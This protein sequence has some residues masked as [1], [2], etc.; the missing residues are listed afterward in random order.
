M[1]WQTRRAK[2]SGEKRVL[3]HMAFRRCV[4]VVFM[5]CVMGGV[6]AHAGATLLLEEPYSY[7]GTFAGTGHV[8]LY[9]DRVCADSPFVLRRCQVGE[10]GVVLSRYHGIA[11]HDWY[12]IPLM[13]YLYA[14]ELPEQ[15]PLFADPKLVSFLRDQ[16]RRKHFSDLVSDAPNG[17]T[18]DGPWVQLVGSSY[19]RTSYAFQIE[20]TPEKDAELIR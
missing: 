20:T 6:H 16:Y 1:S 4:A 2:L 10:Q 17:E 14:V 13:P 8:A 3:S 15:V 7:D 5:L 19:D 11:G 9:L 18:P 12:A